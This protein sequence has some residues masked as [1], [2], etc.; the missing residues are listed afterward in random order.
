MKIIE[1][2]IENLFVA[3]ST[4]NVDARGSFSRLFCQY[5]LSSVIEQR[6]IEQINYSV[7][8]KL[9][10]IRGM[11]FQYPPHSE[12]KIVRC[13]KGMIWDVAIDLRSNSKT[14]LKWHAEVLSE[15]NM[16]FMIIPE[17]FAHGFQ[18][19]KANS[20][21]F[22]LHTASYNKDYEGGI[23]FDDPIVGIKWPMY[24]SDLSSRDASHRLLC[25]EFKGLT[26]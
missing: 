3:E 2:N 9:G 12:M 16:R 4:K 1:T 6:K 8:Q 21:L 24:I 25:S 10:L 17:G 18:V 5:E 15:E 14:F 13:L 20:E 23:R 26:I 22:Y 19:L 7:S 11:H